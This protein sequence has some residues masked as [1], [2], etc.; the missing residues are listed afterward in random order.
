MLRITKTKSLHYGNKEVK[1]FRVFLGFFFLTQQHLA[2]F[3]LKTPQRVYLANN[4]DTDQM[5][6][7]AAND[8]GLHCLDK[9]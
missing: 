2:H 7:N 1:N 3:S 8:Q 9:V 5:P 6:Q 4:A